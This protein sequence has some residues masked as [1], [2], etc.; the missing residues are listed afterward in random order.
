MML[1]PMA[2]IGWNSWHGA[3]RNVTHSLMVT[4]KQ[5]LLEVIKG[6]TISC[7]G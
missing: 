2:K 6:D 1:G 4:Q 7:M 5:G 3:T